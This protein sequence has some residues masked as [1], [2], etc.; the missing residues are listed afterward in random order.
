[1]NNHIIKIQHCTVSFPSANNDGTCSTVLNDITL[2]VQPG[3]FITVVGSSGCGKSTVLSLVLGSQF[4]TNGHVVVCGKSVTRVTRDTGIVYQNYSLFPHLTMLENI[5][6]GPIL[7][8]T[9]LWERVLCKPI[10]AVLD[11]FKAKGLLK[12]IRYS[13]IR[14]D[15]RA[16]ARVLAQRCG[17]EIDKDG[18]KYPFELSGGMRQRVAIAQSL[19]MKPTILLMD[20]AF[21]G[22]DENIKREMRDFIHEQWQENKT[23]IFFVTHDLKE[24]VMLG[25]RLICLSKYWSDE[26]GQPGTGARIVI[27]KQVAGGSELPS[28]FVDSEEFKQVVENTR[29][30]AFDKSNPLPIDAF[31]LSHPD[32]FKAKEQTHGK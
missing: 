25:T 17:L 23:T 30:K 27:D 14:D 32:A 8:G 6:A 1:M 12:R 20:E 2:Q 4:P 29:L 15:A 18:N 24:A 11:F 13:R 9:T 22:L 10:V 21:S 3:E 5:A 31:E 7:D 16:Q 19:A 26:S 28:K